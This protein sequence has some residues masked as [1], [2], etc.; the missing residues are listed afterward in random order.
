MT[1]AIALARRRAGGRAGGSATLSPPEPFH[2]N[3]MWARAL[4]SGSTWNAGPDAASPTRGPRGRLPLASPRSA[5]RPL[6]E[7]RRGEG[8]AGRGGGRGTR[9]CG[10]IGGGEQQAAGWEEK[11]MAPAAGSAERGAGRRHAGRQ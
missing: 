11:N 6:G 4:D 2:P 8:E 3:G 1:A 5:P 9:D 10:E 7:A